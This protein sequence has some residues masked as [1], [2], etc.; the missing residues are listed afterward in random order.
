MPQ[1]QEKGKGLIIGRFQPFHNGHEYL[2]EESQ[3][4]YDSLIIGIGVAEDEGPNNPL[5]YQT[6][7]KIIEEGYDDRFPL[8]K[9]KDQGDPDLWVAEVE[10]QLEGLT[11][12]LGEE[13]EHGELTAITGNSYT[14]YCFRQADYPVEEL[15]KEQLHKP[16]EFNGNHIRDLAA[17]NDERW[18]RLVPDYTRKVLA[19]ADFDFE[20]KVKKLRKET[21][22]KPNWI[23]VEMRY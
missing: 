13:L 2:I 10:K 20:E 5:S 23:S 8:L 9:I 16:E 6:R 19:N 1:E 4:D 15:S 3:K 17:N 14:A 22:G 11:D 12:G 21:E 18:K 7:E